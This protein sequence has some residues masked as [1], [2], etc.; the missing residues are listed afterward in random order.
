MFTCAYAVHVCKI[1]TFVNVCKIFTFIL[2][3]NQKAATQICGVLKGLNQSH[4]RE[5]YSLAKDWTHLKRTSGVIL[6]L[7]SVQQP[8]PPTITHT[9]TKKK[10]SLPHN[11]L[12]LSDSCWIESSC[13][14]NLSIFNHIICHEKRAEN[15][16]NLYVTLSQPGATALYFLWQFSAVFGTFYSPSWIQ[17]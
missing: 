9:H 7:N 16:S 15:N 3:S 13:F 6:N 14:Q 1:F 10:K 4:G 5:D 8:P 11:F 17:E 2:A 12:Y